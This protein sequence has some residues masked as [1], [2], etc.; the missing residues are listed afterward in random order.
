MV[1]EAGGQLSMSGSFNRIRG[2]PEASGP[3]GGKVKSKSRR[4][5][6]NEWGRS[7][8]RPNGIS[9][10]LVY[11]HDTWTCSVQVLK[12]FMLGTNK[13]ARNG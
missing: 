3:G 8:S 2:Q 5:M 7:R 12:E 13:R 4:G 9:V 6:T 1:G 10:D 11:T